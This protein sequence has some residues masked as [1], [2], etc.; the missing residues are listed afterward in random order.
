MHDSNEATIDLMKALHE[1]NAFMHGF[2]KDSINFNE[3][4]HDLEKDSANL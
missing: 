3:F 2:D 4:M 1:F